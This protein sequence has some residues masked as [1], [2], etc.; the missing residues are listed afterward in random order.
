MKKSHLITVLSIAVIIM[1]SLAGCS[2]KNKAEEVHY[3]YQGESA[4]W[5][6][7][8]KIDGSISST[9]Q[10]GKNIYQTPYQ[11][12]ITLNYTGDPSEIDSSELVNYSY[13]LGSIKGSE[14]I[15]FEKTINSK[16]K[17]QQGLMKINPDEIATITITIEDN[18]ETIQ[19]KN[20][21][22]N[23]SIGEKE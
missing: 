8:I 3:I 9:T 4:N 22:T 13:A 20:T 16:H 19:L 5:I 15:D 17:R 18:T 21:Q 11:L 1:A 2:E 23:A 7:E 10:N 12:L 6:G 14:T